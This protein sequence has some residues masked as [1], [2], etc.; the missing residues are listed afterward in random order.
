M[1]KR[2]LLLSILVSV[3]TLCAR[4]SSVKLSWR[5]R[6]KL[7]RFNVTGCG[8]KCKCVACLYISF[9]IYHSKKPRA[10]KVD[11]LITAY[12]CNH[13]GEQI[14]KKR[15]DFLSSNATT[16]HWYSDQLKLL[17]MLNLRL[18][19]CVSSPGMEKLACLCRGTFPNYEAISARK[20]KPQSST[21]FECI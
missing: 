2:S 8:S 15:D 14:R 10:I 21:R 3:C 19:G 9:F 13:M 6:Y 1:K 20:M 4:Y 18:L 5:A 11:Y 16:P 17:N 7:S 12:K